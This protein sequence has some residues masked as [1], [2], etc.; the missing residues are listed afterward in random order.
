MCAFVDKKSQIVQLSS[1]DRCEVFLF[2]FRRLS[3][4]VCKKGPFLPFL[5]LCFTSSSKYIKKK[6]KKKNIEKLN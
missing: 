1:L 6:K 5:E 2:K 3:V 4:T